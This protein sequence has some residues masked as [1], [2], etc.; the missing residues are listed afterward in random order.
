MGEGHS[1]DV[2]RHNRRRLGQALEVGQD[3]IDRLTK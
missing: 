3:R 1:L 2:E